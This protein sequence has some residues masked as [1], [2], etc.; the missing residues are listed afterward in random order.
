M[1]FRNRAAVLANAIKVCNC[2][3]R[4][5]EL[6]NNLKKTGHRV[7]DQTAT[8]SSF[9]RTKLLNGLPLSLEKAELRHLQVDTSRHR[10]ELDPSRIHECSSTSC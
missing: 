9:R 2:S 1:P 4:V 8:F 3:C 5:P 7:A 10:E 6:S